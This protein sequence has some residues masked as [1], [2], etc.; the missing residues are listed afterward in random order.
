MVRGALFLLRGDEPEDDKPETA[1]PKYNDDLHQQATFFDLDGAEQVH[2]QANVPVQHEMDGPELDLYEDA[3]F[4]GADTLN[5]DC[6]L[7][8]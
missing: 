3:Y 6:I 7:D 1:H 4:S 5:E 2:Q 8:S